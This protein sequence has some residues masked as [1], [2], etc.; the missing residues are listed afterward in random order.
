MKVGDFMAIAELVTPLLGSLTKQKV[1]LELVKNHDVFDYL[2]YME[3]GK[4]NVR[5][6]TVKKLVKDMAMDF[7]EA[8]NDLFNK[9]NTILLKGAFWEEFF[10]ER[11]FLFPEDQVIL[12]EFFHLEELIFRVIKDQVFKSKSS[13]LYFVFSLFL[14]FLKMV[15]GHFEELN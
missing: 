6:T 4:F 1:K 7:S 5:D 8:F 3:D 14:F 12:T 2:R 9:S 13:L 10:K 11:Q 15:V